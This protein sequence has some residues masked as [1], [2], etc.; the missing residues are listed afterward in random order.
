[1]FWSRAQTAAPYW[2]VKL[3]S[4]GQATSVAITCAMAQSIDRMVRSNLCDAGRNS[5]K[6]AES[7][8][9]FPPTPNDHKAAKTPMAAKLGAEAAIMP[10]KAVSPNVRLKAHLRPKMSQPKPQ[11]MAPAKRPMFCDCVRSGG[12]GGPASLATGA[13]ISDVTMG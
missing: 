11:K 6:M 8:G 9:R 3:P 12:R 5:R 10:Q 2:Q 13:K 7:T 1:M 4:S